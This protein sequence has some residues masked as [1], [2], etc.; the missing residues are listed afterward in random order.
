MTKIVFHVWN[1]NFCTLLLFKTF[2]HNPSKA[3]L[4]TGL[5][6]LCTVR[7]N[8]PFV[9][10]MILPILSKLQ[11]LKTL[12]RLLNYLSLISLESESVFY[13]KTRPDNETGKMSNFWQYNERCSCPYTP[14]IHLHLL[15]TVRAGRHLLNMQF[16]YWFNSTS[17]LHLDSKWRQMIKIRVTRFSVP[18]S[19]HNWQSRHCLKN[20]YPKGHIAVSRPFCFSLKM[21]TPT[22]LAEQEP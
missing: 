6:A 15:K 12:I 10:T 2:H 17:F 18:K 13:E 20:G 22:Y 9:T 1:G 5:T 7:W 11:P 3:L 16:A 8:R 19:G 4:H 14:M 21:D